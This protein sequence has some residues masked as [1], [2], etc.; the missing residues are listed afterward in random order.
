MFLLLPC[1]SFQCQTYFKSTNILPTKYQVQLGAFSSHSLTPTSWLQPSIHLPFLK[2]SHFQ[3]KLSPC[4]LLSLPS[5]FP[6]PWPL[7]ASVC[8]WSAMQLYSWWGS[9]HSCVKD[10]IGAKTRASP[11]AQLLLMQSWISL[12]HS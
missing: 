12:S 4:S 8:T 3:K 9:R 11:P 10:L 6:A 2:S 7:T 1:V 5:H